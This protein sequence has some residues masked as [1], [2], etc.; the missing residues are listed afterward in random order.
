MIDADAVRRVT[1]SLPQ[2]EDR[3]DETALHVYVRGKQFAWTYLESAGKKPRPRLDVL[4]VLVRL[5]RVDEA[6]RR[7]C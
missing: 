7:P 2:A 5:D 6:A 4:A 1:S 3:S